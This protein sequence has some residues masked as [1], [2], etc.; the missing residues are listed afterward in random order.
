VPVA[1][2]QAMAACDVRK[3]EIVNTNVGK[4]REATAVLN[5]VLA[6]LNLPAA[7][8]DT[9]GGDEIPQSLKEKARQ[10]QLQGGVAE[11]NRLIN[12]IPELVQRNKEILDEVSFL[13]SF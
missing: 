6:S 8:E 13:L 7:V 10:V 12:E 5:S 1:I 11:L 2:H 4:L 9:P 3:T